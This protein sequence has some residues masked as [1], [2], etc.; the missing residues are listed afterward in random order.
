MYLFALRL[1]DLS[2]IIY[3][4]NINDLKE[5]CISLFHKFMDLRH[6]VSM[7]LFALIS[8]IDIVYYIYCMRICY[9]EGPGCTGLMWGYIIVRYPSLPFL[10]I[11]P[12]LLFIEKKFNLKLPFKFINKNKVFIFIWTLF[13]LLSL[14]INSLLILCVFNL[15]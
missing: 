6:Y 13:F 3:S 9:I 8:V 15:I 5:A 14:S 7:N 11:F 2:G 10:I 4:M 12:I 1:C